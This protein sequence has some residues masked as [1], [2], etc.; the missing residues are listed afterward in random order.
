MDADLHKVQGMKTRIFITIFL[1]RLNSTPEENLRFRFS[2][3]LLQI[4]ICSFFL[5][6]CTVTPGS[7]L[8][9]SEIWEQ[10][11]PQIVNWGGGTLRDD[12]PHLLVTIEYP[13]AVTPEA[14]AVLRGMRRGSLLYG[15]YSYGKSESPNVYTDEEIDER[16]LDQLNKSG[17]YAL[18]IFNYLEREHRFPSD[19]LALRAVTIDVDP[20]QKDALRVLRDI[21]P[22]PSVLTLRFDVERLV[23]DMSD[24]KHLFIMFNSFGNAVTPEFV[25]LTEPS[26]WPGTGGAIMSVGNRYW[27]GGAL[28]FSCPPQT[29]FTEG[30]DLSEMLNFLGPF[31]GPG[32]APGSVVEN[33][34]KRSLPFP[35]GL[36]MREI[37]IQEPSSVAFA[38]AVPI[39][40]GNKS[41]YAMGQYIENVLVQA[42]VQVDP[43]LAT[44]I[45]WKHYIA[46]FDKS[47]A[48]RWPNVELT[49]DELRRLS[50]I[51]KIMKAERGVISQQSS[52]FSDAMLKGS[53]G[54]AMRKQMIG[55]YRLVQDLQFADAQATNAT[56]LS[57]ASTTN[58]L[59]AAHGTSSRLSNAVALSRQLISET[60]KQSIAMQEMQS[61]FAF[62]YRDFVWKSGQETLVFDGEQI[63]LSA[64]EALRA[65]LV[66][67]YAS[68]FPEATAVSPARCPDVS[69][70]GFTRKDWTGTCSR[71]VNASS[72]AVG[73]PPT[74]TYYERYNANG[75]FVDMSELSVVGGAEKGPEFT[76]ASC[77]YVNETPVANTLP[78]D[79]RKCVSLLSPQAVVD[80]IR[81]SGGHPTLAYR[82][83]SVW[84]N[85]WGLQGADNLVSL[86][87]YAKF[88]IHTDS[89]VLAIKWSSEGEQ[90][91][92]TDSITKPSR[93]AIGPERSLLDS[94]WA[95]WRKTRAKL[96]AY[97][98]KT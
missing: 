85:G 86:E 62:N 63:R 76:Y 45:Q 2:R 15:S 94:A 66:T 6:S 21:A 31:V 90:Y 92:V 55:E 49:Q 75:A 33:D 89:I 88:S 5:S 53:A 41:G 64:A 16:I 61:E 36:G 79:E 3:V 30:E 83:T 38:D 97:D 26:A 28:A 14:M 25:L 87:R 29:C 8:H 52:Q 34:P 43:Y 7:F 13:G 77:L 73:T 50:Y 59:M 44:R 54:Q 74:E 4:G 1:E 58:S 70:D 96:I 48:M 17:Y 19:T 24:E 37:L 60:S 40:G 27:A 93:P 32:P 81:R 68:R 20:Q 84:M 98:T 35:R 56:L 18:Q 12:S 67:K 11:P 9:G 78:F 95:E 22:I 57:L 10:I 46:I 42:L 71:H 72:N 23:Q 51:K 47:L 91:I 39:G 80:E 65:A 69:N 82:H